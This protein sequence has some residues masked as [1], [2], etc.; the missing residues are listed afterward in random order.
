MGFFSWKCAKSDLPVMSS[1]G[2]DGTEWEWMSHVVVLH[3]DAN[4]FV[5]R[6]AGIYD[7]YGVVESPY[8]PYGLRIDLVDIPEDSWRMVI[9]R[10]YKNDNF[11]SLPKNTNDP[12]QGYF[13]DDASLDE[14]LYNKGIDKPPANQE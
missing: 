8:G 12:G 4:G 6:F 13:Y 14:M 9:E 1:Y 2:V 11:H 10:F 3:K 5:N 7:G